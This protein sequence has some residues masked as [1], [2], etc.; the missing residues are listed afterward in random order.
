MH[1]VVRETHYA[2]DKP[3]QD[4]P[5]FKKFQDAHAACPGYRGTIVTH[6]G[7]GRYA[8]VTLWATVADMD[9]AREA[10]GPVVQEMLDP[11]MTEPSRLYGTGRVVFTDIHL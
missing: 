7:E 9:A 10:L 1:A 5:A 4:L 8:T 6:L 3:L 11:A 2:P